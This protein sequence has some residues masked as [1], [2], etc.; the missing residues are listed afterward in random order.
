MPRLE[1]IAEKYTNDADC[2]TS[3]SYRAL[4]II[5]SAK[6]SY[7]T[8]PQNT[9]SFWELK[10]EMDEFL[11]EPI[12]KKWIK[13]FRLKNVRNKSELKN[14]ILLKLHLYPIVMIVDRCKRR[15]KR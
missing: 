11:S 10:A 7:F 14:I 3:I 15:I 6:Q 8:H 1:K 2:S 12:I 5:M 13:K 4:K 9:K